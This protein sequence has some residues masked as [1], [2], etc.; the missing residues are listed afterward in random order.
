MVRERGA[1]AP[2]PS[3]SKREG[4]TRRTDTEQRERVEVSV[5]WQE[6]DDAGRPE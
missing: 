3:F 5:S 6:F 1:S 2:N 4:R